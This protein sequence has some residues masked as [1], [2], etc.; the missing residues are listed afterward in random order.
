MLKVKL[1]NLQHKTVVESNQASKKEDE[2]EHMEK[3][4]ED[5]DKELHSLK[6]FTSKENILDGGK[7]RKE[8]AV[9][10]S[11]FDEQER[12][13]TP[14]NLDGDPRYAAYNKE[15]SRKLARFHCFDLSLNPLHHEFYF[16]LILMAK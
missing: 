9:W 14:Q 6:Q 12:P 13:S 16:P 11:G 1:S 15:E 3:I 2:D 5:T 4:F 10:T 7:E 8:A